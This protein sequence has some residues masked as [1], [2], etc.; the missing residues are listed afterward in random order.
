MNLLLD[1]IKRDF[2]DRE[3]PPTREYRTL[4]STVDMDS[5][6]YGSFITFVDSDDFEC[7]IQRSAGK[8]TLCASIYVSKDRNRWI[9]TKKCVDTRVGTYLYSAARLKYP[10]RYR[11]LWRF[12]S[13]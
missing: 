13:I 6:A 5:T 2:L 3:N 8:Y 12:F 1:C 10:D 11:Q 4:S 7:Y 9:Y